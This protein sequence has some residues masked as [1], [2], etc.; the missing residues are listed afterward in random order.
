PLHRSPPALH[1][2]QAELKV[3][4]TGLKVV[5]LLCPFARGGKTGLFG[6]AGVGKTVLLMEF[7][8]AITEAHQGLSVFA[9]VGE[10][11]REGHELWQ[12]FARSGL[13]ERTAMVFGQMDAPPGMRFRVPHAALSIAEHFRDTE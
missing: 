4:H 13:L 10:R 6:G 7:I 1:A 12:D 9:G 8:S 11:I 3:L 5:D 2:H